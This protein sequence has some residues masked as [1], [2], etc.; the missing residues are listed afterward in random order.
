[1]PSLRKRSSLRRSA[2]RAFAFLSGLAV[3]VSTVGLPVIERSEKDLSKP[4]PC[5]Q[6]ACGCHTARDCWDHCCCFTDEQKL[7]W[8]IENNV[9][10][11]SDFLVRCSPD[12]RRRYAERDAQADACEPAETEACCCCQKGELPP[13]S[14][15]PSNPTA[16]PASAKLKLVLGVFAAK[17]KGNGTDWLTLKQSLPPPSVV[18]FSPELLV[19]SDL[20]L[21]DNSYEHFRAAPM[22]P[23][24]RHF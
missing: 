24:P 15:V 23:P 17:C 8:A 13:R 6:R 12:L 11:P 3:L 21:C 14:S 7:A 22:P 10:P 2:I 19:S 5:A 18:V 1:M 20:V 16:K 9:D 4:F